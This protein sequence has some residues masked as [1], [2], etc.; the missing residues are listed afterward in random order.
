M[1]PPDHGTLSEQTAL[2]CALAQSHTVPSTPRDRCA[3]GCAAQ[4]PLP[5]KK[6]SKM[7][8]EQEITCFLPTHFA[9]ASSWYFKKFFCLSHVTL[10]PPMKLTGYSEILCNC[11]YVSLIYEKN[12]LVWDIKC[13]KEWIAYLKLS[14]FTIICLNGKEGGVI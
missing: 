9:S 13:Q 12:K 11:Q 2:L 10:L 5:R 8:T 7:I 1:C 3:L 6:Y 4:D 14:S